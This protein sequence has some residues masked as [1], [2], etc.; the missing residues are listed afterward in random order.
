MAKE[1]EETAADR[2]SGDLERTLDL[3]GDSAASEPVQTGDTD[4]QAALA[5]DDTLVGRYTIESFVASGGMGEVYRATDQALGISVALKTIRPR[6]ASDPAALRR[7]KQEVLLARSVSHP[8]VCRIYD[9]G[10]D[11]GRDILFI[12]ME[13]LAGKTLSERI[14]SGGAML[15]A[16]ALP[17]LRQLADA[18]DAAHRA[19]IIHRDFKSEN[20]MLT[21]SGDGAPRALIT[22]F[23]LA[24][25]AR[26]EVGG[27]AREQAREIVG[28]LS[29]M[30]P[31]QLTGGCVGPASDLYSLGVVLFEMVTGRLPF[32]RV[33]SL[34]AALAR[35]ATPAPAPSL[36]VPIEP[37][38]DEVILRLLSKNSADRPASGR[39]VI[40]R[41]E[42]EAVEGQKA[43]HFL[44][45][46]HDVFVGRS[47]DLRV[48]RCRLEGDGGCRGFG[49]GV[50]DA[51]GPPSS[52]LLTLVGPGGTGKT[53]LA[54][55][56]GW[57]SLAR[58]P[59]GVWFGLVQGDKRG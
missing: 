32:E 56:Y 31:E 37:Q 58:W 38:W 12:T 40:L 46:E 18:L 15:A 19:G 10:L 36:F 4:R 44:P 50:T 5:P 47:A 16:D 1:R 52:R 6:I 3:I 28:T 53:R 57:E 11:E 51:V 39:D 35:L 20:V 54:L 17:L 33:N 48:L 14:H 55:N 23:G 7:F 41:L 26:K 43:R 2:E 22:D 30:A 59:G 49:A 9:L 21:V 34:E 24:L 45:A 25:A 42:G 13:Y 29:Y 27:G 8:N